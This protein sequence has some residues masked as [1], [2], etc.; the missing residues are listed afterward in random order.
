MSSLWSTVRRALRGD[1]HDYTA[2][3]LGSAIVLLAIPMVLETVLESVFAVADVFWVS[4]LGAEAV[5][6]VGIT[7]SFMTIVYAIAMG[8]AMAGTAVVARRIGEQDD[9]GAARAAVQVLALGLF[10]SL[11]L[12]ILGVA[13][14]PTLLAAMGASDE[15]VRLG[16]PFTRIMLGGNVVVV[17]LFLTNAVFRG[18]GDATIAMRSLWL[19]NALNIALG[20]CFIFGLGPLPELGVTGA[21]VATTIGRGTG[22][23]YQLMALAAGRGRLVVKRRHLTLDLA[24]MGSLVRVSSTGMLQMLISTAS[25]IG[26]VRILTG[27]GSSVVAGYTIAIRIVM[28]AILPCW[29]LSNAAATLVGQNLGAKQP[30][31]AQESVFVAA[32]YGLWFLG[33]IGV[34]FV[35]AAGPLVGLFTS[36]PEVLAAGARCLRVVGLGFPFYAYAL[37]V[38]AAFNGAG[39]TWTPTL[40]NLFCFWLCEIPLAWMLSQH[41]ALGPTGVFTAIMIAFSLM[42]VVAV[43]MFRR[44][45]WKRQRI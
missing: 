28:F 26:L 18:A 3:T 2:G 33:A 21:A 25:W 34:V 29:G 5:A 41:T 20:P 32:R 8:I 42:A 15:V 36:D 7:E 6:I 35:A 16:T 13:L 22:V 38:T 45:G 10:V 31:R 19:A 17:M 40:I 4:R 39:D 14:A 43:V 30:D 44:G 9:E 1:K 37:V 23:L 24:A 11:G 12:G 27:F